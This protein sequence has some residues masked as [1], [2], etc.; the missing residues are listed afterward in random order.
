MKHVSDK[1]TQYLPIT[2]YKYDTFFKRFRGLMFRKAPIENEGI[3][4][5]P[6]NSIH[7][8]FMF[9]PIDVIFLNDQHQIIYLK[10]NVKPWT[11]IFPIKNAT[12]ALELPAGSISKYSIHISTY[13][14]L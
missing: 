12:S 1:G 8:F 7:M 6:C 11:M 10:E 13:I 5:T 3:L 14:E 4:L 2:I 9:F